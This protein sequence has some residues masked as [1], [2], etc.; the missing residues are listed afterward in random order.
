MYDDCQ[1][2]AEEG[3]DGK[4]DS[5]YQVLSESCKR[6]FITLICFRIQLHIGVNLSQSRVTTIRAN[7]ESPVG[8]KLTSVLLM[9]RAV[10]ILGA[11]TQRKV[12]VPYGFR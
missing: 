12:K 5:E 6:P 8:E 9:C 11:K 4:E 1:I 7:P 2:S 3:D 10:H